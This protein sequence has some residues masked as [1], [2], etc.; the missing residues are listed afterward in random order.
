MRGRQ[1]MIIGLCGYMVKFTKKVE[2]MC[3]KYFED[4]IP[5]EAFA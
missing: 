1:D 2:G 4:K 3:R 5:L